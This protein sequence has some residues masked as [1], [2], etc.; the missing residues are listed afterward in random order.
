M[1]DVAHWTE[2]NTFLGS[3]SEL[4]LCDCG[5]SDRIDPAYASTWNLMVTKNGLHL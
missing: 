5:M 3:G 1:G 4:G 2:D